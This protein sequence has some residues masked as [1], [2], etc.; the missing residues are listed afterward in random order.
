[1]QV[2]KK[3]P[4]LAHLAMITAQHGK[5]EKDAAGR[6]IEYGISDPKKTKVAILVRPSFT[7][8]V[9]CDRRAFAPSALRAVLRT[10]FSPL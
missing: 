5:I 10:F 2:N 8:N 7:A 3:I 1:M 9:L 4:P 6:G